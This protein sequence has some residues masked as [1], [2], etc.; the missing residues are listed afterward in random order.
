MLYRTQCPFCNACEA[1]RVPVRDFRPSKSLRKVWNRN[2]DLDVDHGSAVFSQERL[3]LYNRHK[4][5]RGLSK[6]QRKMSQYS[7]QQW[8]LQSCADTREFR[9]YLDGKLIGVSILDFGREDISSV[10]FYFDPDHS[11]RSLGTFSILYEID[12]MRRYQRRNYYLGLYVEDCS[13]LSY[14]GRFFPHE[15][16]V[17]GRWLR[18]EE[19]HV[20]RDHAPP[21]EDL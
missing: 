18:F 13:H 21:V 17:A 8:F 5:E 15:R 16:R 4:L 6:T 7:Y 20:S 12:W 10:Y 14:K 9:Y 3:M 11:D 19:P 2:S 1:I